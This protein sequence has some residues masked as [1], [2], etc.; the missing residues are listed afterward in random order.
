MA[1]IPTSVRQVR[2]LRCSILSPGLEKRTSSDRDRSIIA[3]YGF[4]VMPFVQKIDI[5]ESIFENTISGS[6]TLVE[7][8]GLSEYIPLVGV[9]V[10]ALAFEIDGPDGTSKIFA[11][12]FRIVALKHQGFPRHDFRMYTLQ[13]VTHEFVQSTAMRVCRA[14]R[15]VTCQAAVTDL[16]TTD[17]KIDAGRLNTSEPTFGNVS[18]TI[19]NYT[20]LMAINYFTLLAQTQDRRNS[21]FM[22]FETLDGFHFT[23]IAKLIT[24]TTVADFNVDGGI[25]IVNTLTD[26]RELNSIMRV[27]QD[28]AFDLLFDIAAGTLRSRLVNFDL[29][30]R[31]IEHVDD[32]R[33]TKTFAQTDHLDKYPVYPDNFD[34]LVSN[35]VRIFTVPSNVWSTKSAYIQSIEQQTPQ[36]L[37]ESIVLRNRQLKEILHVQTLLDMP[38]QPYLRA[39]STVNVFYP[40]S[41]PLQ[42][43]DGSITS[44]LAQ[45]PT[46]Y[47][48]GK[49]LVTSVHH[50]LLA[51]APG[52]MEYRMNVA[53]NRDSFGTPLIGSNASE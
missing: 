32:S 42:G 51:Q 37:H 36:R 21:N 8:V 1:V 49:H 33:Y 23:S 50:I 39:G 24:G 38:G 53:V 3:D 6:I 28:Q 25:A 13:L 7:N 26:D 11:R 20:P 40:S 22:F 29:L 10:L 35:N 18:V 43:E 41:R 27:H 52:S 16:L 19:P 14:Y 2:L 15:D 4:D 46:P 12:T 17:L 47:Y 34:L 48:S 30:A 31:K 45:E 44:P 9:E 5:Y